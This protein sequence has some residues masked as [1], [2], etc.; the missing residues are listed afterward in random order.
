[1]KSLQEDILT[2][3]RGTAKHPS[4]VQVNLIG[5]CTLLIEV[6]ASKDDIE[7]LRTNRNTIQTYVNS[8]FPANFLLKFTQT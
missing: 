1:V 2:F 7:N 5:S 8:T 3:V 6:L 4:Q